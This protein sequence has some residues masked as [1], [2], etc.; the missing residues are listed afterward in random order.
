MCRKFYLHHLRHYY[1]EP[2]I[3]NLSVINYVNSGFHEVYFP[4]CRD[5]FLMQVV[6]CRVKM[7]TGIFDKTVL[8]VTYSIVTYRQ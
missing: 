5:L 8:I 2:E 6:F 1:K 7:I 4:R 3:E